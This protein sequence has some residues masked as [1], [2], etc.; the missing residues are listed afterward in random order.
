MSTIQDRILRI[1][2]THHLIKHGFNVRVRQTLRC[3]L[4][5]SISSRSCQQVLSRVLPFIHRYASSKFTY[6]WECF[7]VNPIQF[8]NELKKELQQSYTTPLKLAKNFIGCHSR[9]S[10]QNGYI[11][12][13]HT[14]Y[15]G[16]S[17]V[18][19]HHQGPRMTTML[20]SGLLDHPTTA[21]Q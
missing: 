20:S 12:G 14:T 15:L 1:S 6:Y 3:P 8:S 11:R 21:L 13:P 5:L 16:D 9:L 19:S 7:I 2:I 4:E 17:R 10:P 18:Q